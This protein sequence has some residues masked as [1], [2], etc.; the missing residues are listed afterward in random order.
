MLIED[1]AARYLAAHEVGLSLA[2]G[3]VAFVKPRANWLVRLMRRLR[4]MFRRRPLD[5]GAIVG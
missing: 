3:R 5:A 2:D 1:R 4:A